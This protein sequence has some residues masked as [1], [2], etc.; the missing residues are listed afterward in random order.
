MDKVDGLLLAQYFIFIKFL[1]IKDYG[2]FSNL[3]K[4]IESKYFQEFRKTDT[5]HGSI[6]V[7]DWKFAIYNQMHWKI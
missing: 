4:A 7:E 6:T 3:F 5:H 2:A 1:I